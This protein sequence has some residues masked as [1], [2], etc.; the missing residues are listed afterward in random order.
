[1]NL[2]RFDNTKAAQVLDEIAKLI[3]ST[4]LDVNHVSGLDMVQDAELLRLYAK[5]LRSGRFNLLITG[6]FN[7]G[8]STLVNAL[9][10]SEVVLTGSVPTTAVITRLIQS[11]DL[12]ITVYPRVGTPY[13]IDRD[14]YVN[15]Y[16]ISRENFSKGETDIVSYQQVDYIE[17]SGSFPLLQEGLT[18]IDTPGL[19]E[20][21]LRTRL[22]LEYLP[23]ANAIV[24]VIDA[25]Q[26]LFKDERN[27]I[28]LLGTDKL[29]QVFFV[30][31]R[32]D[33]L[34]IDELSQ[35]KGWI[36][37][38]LK[39][40]FCNRDGSFDEKLYETR[41]FFTSA[42][43]ASRF[44]SHET[45]N[46]SV[47]PESGV[48]SLR[49]ALLGFL[50]KNEDRNVDLQRL[51]PILA[52]VLYRARQR[53]KYRL[54]VLQQPFE[55]LQAQAIESETRLKQMRQ[56]V[57]SIQRRIIE[58]GEV[59][60]YQIYADLIQYPKQMQ[61]SWSRD[62][63][64]LEFEQLA[65][66]N[67][68]SAKFN[69]K[70][71]Q[72][73]ATLLS[74]ELQRYTQIKLIQWAKQLPDVICPSMTDLVKDIQHDLRAFHL[75]IQ[76]ITA[77]F[78]QTS[79][80][81]SAR[82]SSANFININQ[83]LTLEILTPNSM[84]RLVSSIVDQQLADL[85][86]NNV[87][88]DVGLTVI[89]VILEFVEIIF[90]TKGYLI[91][92]IISRIGRDIISQIQRHRESKEFYNY[93]NNENKNL[94]QTYVSY[95]GTEK[96]EKLKS[97]I[98]ETVSK[99]L[100]IR[101]FEQVH[102]TF[103]SKQ[104]S[105]FQQVEAEFK[106]IS[107]NVKDKLLKT[108]EEVAVEQQQ[109]LES[110]CDKQFFLEQEQ[111]RLQRI[112]VALRSHINT[113][114]MASIQRTLTDLQIE[115][116][117]NQRAVFLEQINS[118]PEIVELLQI[119]VEEPV[120]QNSVINTT[121]PESNIDVI[122]SR[123]V[124]AVKVALGLKEIESND[125]DLAS[126][127]EE[128]ASMIGLRN[129]KQRILE[130]MYYQA[131]NK[132]RRDS[133]LNPGEQQ[134]LHLVFTGNPG[135]GKTTVAESVGKM[136]RR[137]GLLKRGHLVST[138]RADIVASYIGHTEKKV[139]DVIEKARDGVLF[140]DEAYTLVK[141]NTPNDFGVIALEELM[142]WM[143][144]LRGSMAVIVAG[145]P[146]KMKEFLYANPGLMRRF[147]QENI[148]QF[149]D[150]NP[151]E[152][153][154]ILEKLLHTQNYCLS[155]E[156]LNQIKLLI[157]GLFAR[158]DETFGNAGE[159]RNLV[160]AL[161]RRRSLRVQQAHLPV[162]EPIQQEDI[163]EHYQ[164]YIV[165]RPEAD[166][167]NTGLLCIESLIG[168]GTVKTAIR[169]WV[170][171]ARRSIRLGESVR[172]DTLHMIFRGS[173]GTGKTTVAEQC[174]KILHMLGYLR[175]SNLVT[176]NR[177]D[178]VGR[179]I[180][181][182]EQK[183]RE[184][185]KEALDGVLFIDEAYSLYVPDSPQDFGRSVINELTAYM[186]QHRDRLVV[187]L[188]GYSDEINTLLG[189]NPGLRD[190]FR[191]PI[192]FQDYT[193]DELLQI[194]R[195]MASDERYTLSSAAEERIAY[196]LQRKREIDP[197]RFGNARAVRI[198]LDEMKD[199]L[200]LRVSDIEDETEFRRRAKEL[201]AEDVPPLP[202][203]RSPVER[204][205]IRVSIFGQKTVPLQIPIIPPAADRSR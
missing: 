200:A 132:R 2:N 141:D 70:D 131:E 196:Y 135:T 204:T 169:Q 154:Q 40:Y 56:L 181:E 140:I 101:L 147:S 99:E 153:F 16:D 172:A 26:S 166:S 21:S 3:G 149:P 95:L 46:E 90:S 8:K 29:Q 168:L 159:M 61:A 148:I 69:Q 17:I 189:E 43:Y 20:N 137:L 57:E 136:Y 87:L 6:A 58:V 54:N 203:F 85:S 134:S 114:S 170:A 32:V 173:P 127:S 167:I 182:S 96:I 51:L 10:G 117:S 129:V 188:A 111:S 113:I 35:L 45:L 176:V 174:G 125:S 179:H 108:I 190:R 198:L 22:V 192:D 103:V 175:S 162:N 143:E 11:D 4:E 14:I 115:Q 121:V 195:K 78:S 44:S 59:V 73:F 79:R 38:R 31:N 89:R 88:Q 76:D 91:S 118:P 202:E 155:P 146:Q 71:Q 119:E 75:E 191:L 138:T 128:L 48:A 130:L 81:P 7:S 160:D 77:L 120:E 60:K 187:I 42:L 185:L 194:C 34:K 98:K 37:D 33:L 116:L 49:D 165:S 13:Q 97:A 72:R 53:M 28:T 145:Y 184:K 41:V 52:D 65:N 74:D 156:A 27:F 93:R 163:S 107:E 144:K 133:G 158:R 106:V 112:D 199:R 178:L 193:Q 83:D 23:H 177:S 62:V 150:Y 50:K 39:P 183:T 105:L 161:I 164:Q 18:M 104:N 82:L 109:L 186:D 36:K 19:A 139:R 205:E 102:S 24:V 55:K 84:L 124:G 47:G 110:R 5:S 25:K 15:S 142:N 68:F 201:E 197:Q 123:L 94:E 126:I 1:M 92:S 64:I 66:V 30:V 157:E 9:L 12:T 122:Y 180:G 67:I 86:K 63:E 151:D 100:D 80:V 152:L 171:R